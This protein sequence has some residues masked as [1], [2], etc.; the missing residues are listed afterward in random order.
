MA[1]DFDIRDRKRGLTGYLN[2]VAFVEEGVIM[3]KDGAFLAGFLYVG[4]DLDSAVAEEIIRLSNA[5]NNAFTVLG[6]NYTVHVNAIRRDAAGY[7]E[8][9]FFP[10]RTTWLIDQERREMAQAS[11]SQFDS[12]YVITISWLPPSEAQERATNWLFEE[13]GEKMSAQKLLDTR[14]EDFGSKLTMFVNFLSGAD[15]AV[16][17]MTS[18]ELLTFI[19]SCITG[20]PTPIRVPQGMR[21]W[22]NRF[23]KEE[24]NEF[25]PPPL[26]VF[27]DTVLGSQDFV[28]GFEPQVGDMHLAIVSITGLPSE[29]TPGMLDVLNRLSCGY[30]WSTRFISMGQQAAEK[31]L[32]LITRGWLRKQ[33]SLFTVLKNMLSKNPT[34]PPPKPEV[35][36]KLAQ[37]E[38]LKAL[39]N[40]GRVR[41]GFYN[42]E[43]ILYNQN[44]DML[45]REV[46]EIQAAMGS[47][48]F[49]TRLEKGNAV[50]AFFGSL[51]GDSFNNVRRVF[52]AS[53]NLVD[54]LPLTSVWPGHA[55]NKHFEAPAL[56]H[57]VS[58]SST[59][60]RLNLHVEDVG[61]TLVIGPTGMGKSTL[62]ML[63]AA[64]F[65]R[66]KNARVFVFDKGYSALK[67][68]LAA[69]GT[70]YDILSPY[71]PD[72]LTLC[73]LKDIGNSAVDL[74]WGV[75]FISDIVR[76]QQE[77]TTIEFGPEQILAIRTA[78]EQQ[79]DTPHK[80][81]T[82][83]YNLVQDNNV[84]MAIQPYL[85]KEDDF[86]TPALLDADSDN[87]SENR[88][89]TFEMEHLLNM[90]DKLVIPTLNYLFRTIEKQLSGQ[91]SLIILDE[92]WLFLK[93]EIFSEKIQE[94][95]KVLRKKN[96]SVVFAT[97]S[98]TDVEASPISATLY[99]SCPTKILLANPYAKTTS[100]GV[101]QRIGLNDTE[102]QNLASAPRYSYY[103]TSVNGRRLFHLRLGPVQMA[104]LAGAGPDN[105]KQVLELSSKHGETWPFYYL[106]EKGL[107]YAA[108][109]WV[110]AV[111]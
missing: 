59:P 55:Y 54:L 9:G 87:I 28:G 110:K 64:Q 79:K 65:F 49:A 109:M 25:I 63:L 66:Y 1:G 77:K 80:S 100:I 36:E 60:F 57:T 85:R 83:F 26:Y 40:D 11:G 17:R 3:Q 107:E 48:G 43:V 93:N 99:E 19:H 50:R 45:R 70:H 33:Y 73:P 111:Q 29:T 86:N 92:A 7:P 82:A 5:V 68:C 12:V 38:E 8:G 58:Y 67:L 62:L 72:V 96:A 84:K 4:P 32:S 23:V 41:F 101:Y 103:Y 35:V 74:A 97:Q 98:L 14:L 71:S 34:T 90:G 108:D 94:W 53:S 6:D 76:L 51:P 42:T 39:N 104:F 2:Y 13:S 16:R 69:A 52:F 15:V 88:F 30:R 91:P 56:I 20:L 31:Q 18:A 46:K 78:L 10:D 75:E 27:L 44:R 47:L 102:I 106:K 95:L 81:L 22:I 105:T 37:L 24:D 61:H 89:L 21:P